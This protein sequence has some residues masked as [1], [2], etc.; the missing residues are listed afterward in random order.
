MNEQDFIHKINEKTKDL[1]IPAGVSPEM[2]NEKLKLEKANFPER[3]KHTATAPNGRRRHFSGV[4]AAACIVLC[5]FGTAGI[6]R[7]APKKDNSKA[8]Q[9]NSYMAVAPDE[10]VDG[11]MAEE[12]ITT[13]EKAD[14]DGNMLAE[15]TGLVTPK[16]Y[17]DYYTDIKSAYDKYYDSISTVVTND[18]ALSMDRSMKQSATG[19][20][21]DADNAVVGTP[22]SESSFDMKSPASISALKE[23]KHSDTNTQ[24]K[25][26]DEGDIIKTDGEYIYKAVNKYDDRTGN[27]TTTLSITKADKGTLTYMSDI[28][29]ADSGDSWNLSLEEFYVQGNQLI[30]MLRKM[31]YGEKTAY[32]TLIDIYDITDKK[33]PKKVK[34]HTQSGSLLS[35]RISGGY[36]YTISNYSEMDFSDKKLYKNYI[37]CVNGKTIECGRIYYPPDSMVNS[38]KVITS[39]KL[40]DVSKFQDTLTLP[41]NESTVYVSEQAMYF[42]ETIYDSVTKTKISKVTYQE[43]KFTVGNSAT[44]AGYLY[45]PFAINEY[46]NHLRIVATIPANN[47]SLLRFDMQD[48]AGS[49]AADS[50]PAEDVNALYVL[51]DKLNLSGK[52]TGIAPGEIIYSARFMGNTGYFVTYKNTDPLFSVDL[53]DPENPEI[54]GSLKIPGFSNYMHFYGDNILLGIGEETDPDTQQFLGLK[55]SMFDINDPAKVTEEDKHILKNAQYSEAL[56]NYKA[57]MIDPVKNIFGFAYWCTDSNDYRTRYYYSTFAYDEK[58]GFIETACYEVSDSDYGT[59]AI[60]GLYIG[61]YFYLTTSREIRSFE[62]GSETMIDSVKL[63]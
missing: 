28:S 33:N 25:N 15:Q 61:D 45:G 26:V 19:A 36:L 50:A 23:E 38:T 46:D 52:I 47:I 14:V 53:S 7:L 59:D 56:Y 37:P 54:I 49:T 3:Q 51:D 10:S 5:L 6:I 17:E 35:S 1:E 32:T 2:I 16:S 62:I 57:I 60:R 24:E 22:E 41:G 63:Q 18:E 29:A 20:S 34:N 44:I 42:Y 55:L 4:A 13:G 9:E 43:G 31:E 8:Y 12:N 39:L 48:V 27:Y 40:S 30:L 11:S 58:Y 21:D